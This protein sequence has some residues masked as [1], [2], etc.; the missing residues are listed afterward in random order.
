LTALSSSPLPFAPVFPARHT[1]PNSHRPVCPL[2]AARRK[3][4]MDA[5]EI[6]SLMCVKDHTSLGRVAVAACDFVAGELILEERPLL[7]WKSEPVDD[8]LRRY[9]KLTLADR[10]CVME[11]F[12][13]DAEEPDFVAWGGLARVEAMVTATKRLHAPLPPEMLEIFAIAL[14]NGHVYSGVLSETGVVHTG[15]RTADGA[16]KETSD[17]C[18]AA[19]FAALSWV[20]HSCSPNAVYSSRHAEANGAGRLVAIQPVSAGERL[21]I[22]YIDSAFPLP[23]A[24]RQSRLRHRYEFSY[25]CTRCVSPDPLRAVVCPGNS[26]DGVATPTDGTATAWRCASCKRLVTAAAVKAVE[27]AAEATLDE[28]RELSAVLLGPPAA[29]RRVVATILR[30]L[31]PTHWLSI[32]AWRHVEMVAASHVHLRRDTPAALANHLWRVGGGIGNAPAVATL[33]AD[34]ADAAARSIKAVECAAVACT[35]GQA[36]R[37]PHPPASGVNE[38]AFLLGEDLAKLAPAHP[39]PAAALYVKYIPMMAASF[40]ATDKDVAAAS[41]AISG[42]SGAP[43]QCGS[44]KCG[45]G[46][47]KGDAPPPVCLDC[48]AVEYCSTR[49]LRQDKASHRRWCLR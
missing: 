29:A 8:L 35:R 18:V 6:A 12:R 23:T 39:R 2:R 40:G 33:I 41:A 38:W 14:F 45:K 22:S 36:C 13:P 49:C 17:K 7:T 48:G 31:A 21:S 16:H 19:L 30:S 20:E 43:R 25:A 5:S 47:G 9:S 46:V 24:T 26:C 11:L 42:Q 32:G 4:K 10:R 3:N 28:H 27:A 44:R 1:F 15:G 34:A 37:A